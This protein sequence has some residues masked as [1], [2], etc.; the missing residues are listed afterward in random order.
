MAIILNNNKLFFI[1]GDF[2]FKFRIFISI[3]LILFSLLFLYFVFYKDLK[4]NSD[5]LYKTILQAENLNNLNEK[6]SDQVSLENKNLGLKDDIE[7]EFKKKLNFILDSLKSSK[8]KLVDLKE[9]EHISKKKLKNVYQK[10]YYLVKVSG[11][12]AFLST[13]LNKINGM[14]FL[15][16]KTFCILRMSGEELQIDLFFRIIN[17]C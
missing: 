8:L 13:F 5:D 3:F 14:N 16:I 6:F 10:K 11:S 2:S 12:F 17:E 1:C 4:V 9:I 7:P 15:Y